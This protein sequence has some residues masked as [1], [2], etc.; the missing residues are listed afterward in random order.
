MV[1]S[2]EGLK[3]KRIMKGAFSFIFL[4]YNFYLGE[5]IR[6]FLF[7]TFFDP[8][9]KLEIRKHKAFTETFARRKPYLLNPS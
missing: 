3:E 4:I 5:K 1:F 9:R 6:I 8:I 7:F 2:D